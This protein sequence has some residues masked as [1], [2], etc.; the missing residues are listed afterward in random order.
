M[1]TLLAA[2]DGVYE[3]GDTIVSGGC[4][5]GGDNFAE[6]IAKARH[7]PIKIHPADW[8]QGKTAGFVRNTFIAEDCDIL[9]ALVAFNRKGGAEDTI[10][11]VEAMGK[12]IILL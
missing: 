5:K 9:L 8:S 11:K 6:H 3:P 10:S 4:H 2:F 12:P 1:V 7:I